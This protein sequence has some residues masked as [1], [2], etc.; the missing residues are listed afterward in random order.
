MLRAVLILVRKLSCDLC[1][2]RG[3]SHSVN[4]LQLLTVRLLR[5]PLSTENRL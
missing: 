5:T 2:S 4:A 3:P 1:T